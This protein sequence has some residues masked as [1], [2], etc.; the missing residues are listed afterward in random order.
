MLTT[1]SS[2]PDLQEAHDDNPD[3]RPAHVPCACGND[4]AAGRTGRDDDGQGRA[5]PPAVGR[6]VLLGDG[7]GGPPPPRAFAVAAPPPPYPCG[8][9]SPLLRR[10]PAPPAP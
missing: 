3:P 5:C 10:S 9:L 6:R 8:G 1:F 2:N 4:R 7:R